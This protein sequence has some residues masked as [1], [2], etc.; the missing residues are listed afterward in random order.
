ML[1]FLCLITTYSTAK[2][3]TVSSE[4]REK[5]TIKKEKPIKGSRHPI[6]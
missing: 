2:K 6:N 3:R 4:A 1:I 5:I